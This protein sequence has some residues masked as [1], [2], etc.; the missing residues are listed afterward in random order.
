MTEEVFSFDPTTENDVTPV[1]LDMLEKQIT[2]IHAA[3]ERLKTG[4]SDFRTIL[5]KRTHPANEPIFLPG[6]G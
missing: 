3:L 2:G 1:N 6:I 4:S 5:Q